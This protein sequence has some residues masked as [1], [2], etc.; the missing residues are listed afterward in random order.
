MESSCKHPG[1]TILAYQMRTLHGIGDQEDLRCTQFSTSQE[2]KRFLST[3]P[4][5]TSSRQPFNVKRDSDPTISG[6]HAQLV[7]QI[8]HLEWKASSAESRCKLSRTGSNR[9]KT[10]KTQRN[11]PRETSYLPISRLLPFFYS[12]KVS[13]THS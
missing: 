1:S 2:I 4:L 9:I 12:K 11:E 7:S 13:F 3:I 8:Q 5:T 6:A 10:M